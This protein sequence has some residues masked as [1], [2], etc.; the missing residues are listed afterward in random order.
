MLAPRRGAT[1]RS[2][3]TVLA[4]LDEIEQRDR[5]RSPRVECQLGALDST[6]APRPASTPRPRQAAAFRASPPGTDLFRKQ[7]LVGPT[8][9]W[10]S[11]LVLDVN[12]APS[13][14][15]RR[16]R[17]VDAALAAARE[18]ARRRSRRSARSA[19]PTSTPTSTTTRATAGLRYFPLF[20]LFVIV[21]NS[22]L[23]RSL[24]ALV[25]FLLTLGV[26]AALTV[27][28]IGIT[29]GTFTIV[30]SLVPM[31]ILITCTA[32]LV[33][34]H[35]RFVER[36]PDAP[37]S[38]STRSSRWR[39]SSSPAPRRSSRPRSASRRWRSRRSARSAR[40][41]SGSRSAW[42][43]LD[44]RRSRSSRRC[45]RILR[46]PTERER[47]ARR[48][49]V[50]AASPAGCRRSS[51]RWRWVLVPGAL[52]P[53]RRWARS[54]SSAS[55]ACSRRCSLETNA[56]E[57]ITHDSALYQRHQAARGARSRA[58]SITEVWL[59]TGEHGFGSVTDAEVLRG[60]RPLPRR[61]RDAT[62]HV[63]AVIGPTTIL[64]TLR[65]VGG[66]G[67]E[68]PERRRRARGDR[69]T[70]RDA[71][72]REPMLQRF[73]DK[74]TLAET[75]LSVVTRMR[76]GPGLAARVTGAFILPGRL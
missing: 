45:R 69:R 19:S 63:G 23:Y 13:S 4:A 66:K 31:T 34:L 24:R 28:Y 50:R 72:A 51:Y 17:R 75:H 30:S 5:A 35:S 21:L 2:R 61:A 68:L 56:V 40:W 15:R 16:A 29:G 42:F 67:D 65:Y 26:C 20:C 47:K 41:A 22:L 48:P 38:T 73:V 54:R 59:R 1:I 39:T 32:T 37:T 27:G 8:T 46:T 76:T 62:A 49:V 58:S 71:A 70:A 9:S 18:A 3:P 57:Y 6:G 43:H 53:V 64:R 52:R 10:R 36:P 60:A 33:Y 74:T 14:A 55:P 12:G 25:A 44:H 7:G 11:P